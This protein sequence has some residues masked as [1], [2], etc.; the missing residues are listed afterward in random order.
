MCNVILDD[1]NLKINIK[2]LSACTSQVFFFRRLCNIDF[3]KQNLRF[4]G[5]VMN[6][7]FNFSDF[8]ITHRWLIPH[9]LSHHV[10]RNPEV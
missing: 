8:R 4:G 2:L 7:S 1:I 5:R 6:I 3:Q 10:R 9:L